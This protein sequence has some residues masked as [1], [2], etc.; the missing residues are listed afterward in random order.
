MMERFWEG[1][2]LLALDV[3]EVAVATIKKFA[4]AL[5]VWV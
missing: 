2:A 3:G 5:V 1:D 4:S